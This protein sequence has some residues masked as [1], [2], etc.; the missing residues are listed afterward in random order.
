[1]MIGFSGCD[2]GNPASLRDDFFYFF[3]RRFAGEQERA[4]TVI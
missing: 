2:R 1:M 3:T 4:V